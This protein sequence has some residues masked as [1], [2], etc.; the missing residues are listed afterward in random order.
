MVR[1]VVRVSAQLLYAIA[2]EMADRHR[3]RGRSH[4]L[5]EPSRGAHRPRP[6]GDPRVP[7]AHRRRGRRAPADRGD[8]RLRVRRRRVPRPRAVLRAAVRAGPRARRPHRSARAAGGRALGRR[9][10]RS[11]RRRGV[12]AVRNLPQLPGR[13]VPDVPRQALRR[14]VDRRA[15]G[16]VR[17]LRRLPVPAPAGDRPPRRRQHPGCCSC[18]SRSRT[19]CTGRRASAGPRSAASSSSSARVRTASDA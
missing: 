8:G 18:T 17:R 2:R 10:R 13:R 16:A 5:D 7:A 12:P 14:Q 4:E 15:A 9:A 1:C 3:R 19:G 11:H 6:A